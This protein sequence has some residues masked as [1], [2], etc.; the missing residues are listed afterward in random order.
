MNCFG[1]EGNVRAPWLSG[2]TMWLTI[3]M[4]TLSGHR[5][6]QQTRFRMVVVLGVGIPR[7][8][9]RIRRQDRLRSGRSQH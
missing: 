4:H 8:G 1:R 6:S 2:S 5:M 7:A 9:S 3:R